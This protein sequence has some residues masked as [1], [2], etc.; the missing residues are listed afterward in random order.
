MRDISPRT[1]DRSPSVV[2]FSHRAAFFGKVPGSPSCEG[3]RDGDLIIRSSSPLVLY[4][5]RATVE[6][7][8]SF[9]ALTAPPPH[10]RLWFR[11]NAN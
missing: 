11:S 1:D 4:S 10:P 6:V 8:T 2:S 5:S 3:K 7:R 9:Q